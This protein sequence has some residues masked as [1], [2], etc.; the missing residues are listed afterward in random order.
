MSQQVSLISNTIR[1]INSFPEAES[2]RGWGFT[3]L[4]K[5]VWVSST[6]TSFLDLASFRMAW[7]KVEICP[8]VGIIKM[9]NSVWKSCMLHPPAQ[10]LPIYCM[11][12][13]GFGVPHAAIQTS[14]WVLGMVLLSSVGQLWN[15]FC[16]TSVVDVV[17]MLKM[18]QFCLLLGGLLGMY[19]SGFV[20]MW[21]CCHEIK[22]HN[23]IIRF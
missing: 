16:F 1:Q 12:H 21:C 10:N 23:A 11:I 20:N 18:G 9:W 19:N 14:F 5:T 13:T 2:F 15:T 7:N 3:M 6:N 4:W 8:V 22:W 17:Y